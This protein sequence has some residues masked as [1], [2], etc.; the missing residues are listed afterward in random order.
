LQSSVVFA[1]ISGGPDKIIQTT[2][3]Q[4]KA[5]AVQGDDGMRVMTV[6][7][8]NQGVGGTQYWGDPVASLTALNA[9]NT[10][11]LKNGQQRCTLDTNV[12]YR[13][14][15]ATP[16]WVAVSGGGGGGGGTGLQAPSY[17]G[18]VP[19]LANAN[20]NP[21]VAVAN[22][23]TALIDSAGAVWVAGLQSASYQEWGEAVSQKLIWYQLTTISNAKG[24]WY[25][26]IGILWVLKT[27]NTLWVAGYNGLGQLGLGST[28]NQPTF[29]QTMT[30][31][32]SVFINKYVSAGTYVLRIDGSLLRTGNFPNSYT[33]T[34]V[35]ATTSWYVERSSAV[36]AA[37]FG[38]YCLLRIDSDAQMWM[39]GGSTSSDA[40]YCSPSSTAGTGA[41][42]QVALAGVAAVQT[43]CVAYNS[44]SQYV[45]RTDGTLWAK[46][47]NNLGQLGAFGVT[48]QA[49]FAQV[50]AM[51][52]T[53]TLMLADQGGST[54]CAFVVAADGSLWSTGSNGNYNLGLGT[55]TTMQ[56]FTK[57]THASIVNVVGVYS[58]Q[59]TRT[60]VLKSDGTMWAVGVNSSG[61]NGTGSTTPATLTTW[62]RIL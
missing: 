29:I 17:T 55:T 60:V 19:V 13:W 50:T 44:C 16:A 42:W 33:Y 28:V 49:T 54:A 10:A 5:G 39:L 1:V 21:I 48:P 45:I 12:C 2:C 31:V 4:A 38:G 27:D 24:I 7:Q 14:N 47:A 30:S 56:A 51:G 22:T 11:A 36:T 37:A 41:A 18:T 59:C 43:S 58:S 3:A 62:T 15:S 53:N 57:V 61:Q 35:A 6:A 20:G 25:S 46:G 52:A 8:L 40:T 23:A 26:P 34:G 9:L 32:A